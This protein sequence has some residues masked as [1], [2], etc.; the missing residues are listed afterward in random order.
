M[1][2]QLANIFLPLLLH[3]RLRMGAAENTATVL[4]VN[5]SP[6]Y[7]CAME[8][9]EFTIE[10]T[11]NTSNN[12]IKWFAEWNKTRNNVTEKVC[13]RTD[14]IIL[15]A[16]K[17][18]RSLYLTV[19][20]ADITDSGTYICGVGSKQGTSPGKGTQV[21]IHEITNL[22]VNQT[23][24]N[25]SD[26]EGSE[27]TM[28]CTFKTVN[29]HS[30]MHVR[31]Y[32]Y[33][34]KR[35]KKELVNESDVITT[36]HLDNG[37]ASLTLK[38]ANSSNTGTYVCEVGITARNISGNG[39]GTHVTI[40]NFPK[41]MVNQTP[42]NINASEGSDLTMECRFTALKKYNTWYVKWYKHNGTGGMKKEL[43]SERGWGS[44]ALA[45]EKGFVSFA[46]KNVNVTDTGTYV[47]EVGSTVRN[48]SV[49][50][51]GTQVTI[52]P[53]DLLVNQM[54]AVMNGLEGKMLTIECRFKVV[55][56]SSTMYSVTW[57]KKGADGHEKELKNGTGIVTT[58]LDSSKGLASLTLIKIN[59]NDSGLYRC[60]FGKNGVG[61]GTRVTIQAHDQRLMSSYIVPGAAAG[62]LLFLLVFGILLWR[63][64]QCSKVTQRS[65]ENY[66]LG[67][68]FIFFSR[69]TSKQVRGRD[70]S[71]GD[72][73]STS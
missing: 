6:P 70:E 4:L 32:S 61:K 21:T 9:S 72:V 13:N 69:T 24:T 47:C 64:R 7:I 53:V 50:G 29:N 44:A 11:F 54:P 2:L 56:D 42:A 8:G 22:M 27:L 39:P 43:M 59:R 28:N 67:H 30:T 12:S 3:L 14:R 15:S 23:P 17:E 40:E 52:T 1:S 34:T 71:D 58:A 48:S 35:L 19:K 25:F 65:S 57:Y 66:Q 60:D 26:L 5:M 63:W 62:T 20:K 68:N 38:N 41:L 33:E 49:S 51:V 18:K 16:D 45:L 31:W 10:C 37:F 46:L 73:F 55:K 36:L